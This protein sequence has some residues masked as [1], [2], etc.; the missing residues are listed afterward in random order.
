MSAE[1]PLRTVWIIFHEGLNLRGYYTYSEF[2]INCELA[3]CF[4]YSPGVP[5]YEEERVLS[6]EEQALLILQGV[7]CGL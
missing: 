7:I 3:N 6:P 5:I 2:K 1:N 4:H